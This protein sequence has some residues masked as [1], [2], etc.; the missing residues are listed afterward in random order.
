MAPHNTLFHEVLNR[1]N[2]VQ[3]EGERRPV[4]S[5]NTALIKSG[6]GRARGV[7]GRVILYKDHIGVVAID[8]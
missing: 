8:R 7:R 1:L 3:I 2:G 5:R 6:D 4:Y